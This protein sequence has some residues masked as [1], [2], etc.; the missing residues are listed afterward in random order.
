MPRPCS[1]PTPTSPRPNGA[2]WRRS[3]TRRSWITIWPACAWRGC[4]RPQLLAA[5]APQAG[6]G[7]AKPRMG[8]AEV[9][10][11]AAEIGHAAVL[12]LRLQQDPLEWAAVDV[13]PQGEVG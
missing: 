6:M 7:T 10:M 11:G 9:R 4:P 12:L 5:R 13:E 1:A 8:A 2:R 3:A